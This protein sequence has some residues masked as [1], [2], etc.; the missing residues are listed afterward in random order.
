M[1]SK[2]AKMSENFVIKMFL[3]EFRHFKI[4]IFS[5]KTSREFSDIF[6]SIFLNFSFPRPKI[7]KIKEIGNFYL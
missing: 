3:S 1:S 2:K 6:T 5:Q 4:P 7:K